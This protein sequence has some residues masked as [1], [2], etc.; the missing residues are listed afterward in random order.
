ML[1]Q[2]LH[3]PARDKAVYEALESLYLKSSVPLYYIDVSV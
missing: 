3:K 1:H 2:L